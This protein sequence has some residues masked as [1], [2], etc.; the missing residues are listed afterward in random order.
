[1]NGLFQNVLTASFHG[2]IVILAVLFLRLVLRKASR[3][4]ICYLWLL[5]GLRLLM[6]FEIQSD[7]SLQPQ[8]VPD[9]VIRWEKPEPVPQKYEEG[10]VLTDMPV[11][12]VPDDQNAAVMTDM[13]ETKALDLSFLIPTI[14][15]SVAA[16]FGIVSL[17]SYVKLKA[18]VRDAIKIP[19]GW[20]SEHIDTAFILG[21]IRPRIYIPMGMAPVTRKHI[22]SHER[23]HL[24]K[25]DH[26][27]K[28]IGFLALALHWFNPLVWV[29]YILLCKD[30]EMACDERVVQFMELEERKEYSAA[31][32]RCS[33]N[34]IHYAATPVAF[35]EVSVKSRI[36]SI[37]HY[38]KPSFWLGFL[39]ALAICFVTLCL[40]T[41]PVK[42][43][44]SP[45]SAVRANPAADSTEPAVAVFAPA[46]RP[47]MWDNPDWGMDLIANAHT[48]TTMTFRY[49]IGLP[50]IPWD[51]TPVYKEQPYWFEHWDG[52]AW[53]KLPTMTKDPFYE[54]SSG[55]ELSKDNFHGMYCED[56][57]DWSLIYGPLPEGDYRIGITLVRNGEAQAHYAWFHIYANQ[58]SGKEAEAVQRCDNALTKLSSGKNADGTTAGYSCTVYES[59]G[60]GRLL[61]VRTYMRSNGNGRIDSYVGD[62][63]YN[64]TY[65]D[66]SAAVLN[67]WDQPFR[68]NQNQ[69]ISFPEGESLISDNEIRYLSQWADADDNVY[70]QENTYTFGESGKLD[71]VN[72]M[73]YK[74]APDGTVTQSQRALSVGQAYWGDTIDPTLTPKDSQEASLESP[75]NIFFRVDDDY[76]ASSGGEVWFAVGGNTIGATN[77]TTDAGY[78]LEKRGDTTW[79]KL[80]SQAGD[81]TWGSETYRLGTV[82][83]VLNV[84]WTQY[85]GKLEPGLYRMGKHFYSGNDSIIQYAEFKVNPEGSIIGNGG[86][87]A[88]DRINAA[89]ERLKN[90]NS[91]IIQMRMHAN[92]AEPVTDT[93]YWK[94]KDICI[95]D[96]YNYDRGD[97]Y[98]HSAVTRPNDRNADIFYDAWIWMLS[99][100][101]PNVTAYFADG[102]SVISD[103]EITFATA[104]SGDSAGAYLTWH[105]VFFDENG[106]IERIMYWMNDL[107][108]G[109]RNGTTTLLIMDTPE[110]EIQAWA[111]KILAGEG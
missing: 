82:T 23:T 85:Y 17:I 13:P 35:G 9:T 37:L 87:E 43:P 30:I 111:E 96:Y 89:V 99:W 42:T 16:V 59:N 26:W 91:H 74:T 93:I 21:F 109:D 108:D 103:R 54:G 56:V 4:Y 90:R 31:L 24:D 86:A 28:M 48:P 95:Q 33:T 41:S 3:K 61:P 34:K 25:G 100:Q 15:M 44:E 79:E 2:S 29:A 83:T 19:G 11:I 46:K 40:V 12:S 70:R 102:A 52:T 72:Q 105:S 50:G 51:G 6:P 77:Y 68:T 55:M 5:A 73:I 75:W 84:D 80:P 18:K 94:Y 10:E 81:P 27:I 20:E 49:G 32:L 8:A 88:L 22:L 106:E 1:M 47:P 7:F 39:S 76:L 38:R 36:L 107:Y 57:L 104:F 64:T 60:Y 92:Q 65:V 14:W 63:C 45:D 58:L 67:S 98:Q 101:N 78:W 62:I 71:A 97:G 53:E 69:H 110:A 66:V